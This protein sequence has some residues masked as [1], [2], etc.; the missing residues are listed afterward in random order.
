MIN[1]KKSKGM[2][3]QKLRESGLGEDLVET[4]LQSYS[5][6][7]EKEILTTLINRQLKIHMQKKKNR[8][9]IYDKIATYL[10]RQGFHYENFRDILQRKVELRFSNVEESDDSMDL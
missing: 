6:E 4:A 2:V 8:R 5:A 10:Y 9:E 3:K 7:D 1:R